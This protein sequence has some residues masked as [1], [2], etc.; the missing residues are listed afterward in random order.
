MG[1]EVYNE[2]LKKFLPYGQDTSVLISMSNY[3]DYACAQF[4]L[5]IGFTFENI[6]QWPPFFYMQ[7]F[8]DTLPKGLLDLIDGRVYEKDEHPP[9]QYLLGN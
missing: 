6:R 9:Y 4:Q 8:I 1:Q 3:K 5:Y 2:V 7:S